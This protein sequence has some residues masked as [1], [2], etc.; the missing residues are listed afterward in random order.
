M[1]RPIHLH[2]TFL[3]G[4]WGIKFDCE[5]SHSKLKHYPKVLVKKVFINFTRTDYKLVSTFAF[6]IGFTKTLDTF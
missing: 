3:K 1:N 4:N 6:N 2:V 5:L